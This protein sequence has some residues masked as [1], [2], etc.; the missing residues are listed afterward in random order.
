M[1]LLQDLYLDRTRCAN[2]KLDWICIHC[3]QEGETVPENTKYTCPEFFEK[4]ICTLQII[5]VIL[6]NFRSLIR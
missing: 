5:I 3:F 6:Y 4:F 1:T 2:V